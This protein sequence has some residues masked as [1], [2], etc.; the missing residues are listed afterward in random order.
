MFAFQHY[1]EC[2]ISHPRK[3]DESSAVIKD[4][5]GTWMNWMN[6]V[7]SLVTGEPWAALSKIA[8]NSNTALHKHEFMVFGPTVPDALCDLVSR[9]MTGSLFSRSLSDLD[10]SSD[11]GFLF[12]TFLAGVPLGPGA[13][14]T[15]GAP[16][17]QQT[18]LADWG[19]PCRLIL[20]PSLLVALQRIK[21]GLR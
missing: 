11:Q 8:A 10:S 14:L 4:L 18:R 5:T 2:K 9:G 20:D 15:L 17:T 12:F 16:A 3:M 13:F 1:R 7:D 19:A 6:T 21:Q